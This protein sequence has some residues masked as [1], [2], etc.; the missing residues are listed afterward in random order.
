MTKRAIAALVALGMQACL[1]IPEIPH[2]R[3]DFPSRENMD[4]PLECGFPQIGKSTREEVLS[5]LGA[6]DEISPDGSRLIYRWR[7]VVAEMALLK[8]SFPLLSSY[9]LEIVCDAQGVVSRCE[10]K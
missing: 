6:P 2:Y 3:D 5:Q 4:L 10:R 8:S 9:S 1:I 7:K